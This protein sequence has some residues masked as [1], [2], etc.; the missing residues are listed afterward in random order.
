[1]TS[2]KPSKN[3]GNGGTG[4]YMR[5]GADRPYGELCDFYSVSHECFGYTLVHTLSCRYCHL[6]KV[7]GKIVNILQYV[8]N[9]SVSN[10]VNEQ[11]NRLNGA[12]IL[13]DAGTC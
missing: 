10:E 12:S 5:E 2:R 1:M 9:Y 3:G 8:I 4:V 13:G 7:Y 11:T 6:N